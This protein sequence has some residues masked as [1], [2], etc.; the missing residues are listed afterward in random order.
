MTTITVVGGGL[1]GL[2][3]GIT[4]AEAGASVELHEA[5]RMLGGR[6]RSTQA[7]FV[8]NFGP[9]A[10][11][12][13]GQMWAWLG[14]RGLLP[15]CN[16]PGY[17][18]VLLRVDGRARGTAPWSMVRSVGLLRRG[19]AP[20]DLDFRTW[21]AGLYGDEAA[22]RWSAAAGVFSFTADPGALSAAFV[23][24]RLV[25]V[26]GL[27]LQARFPVGGWSSLVDRMEAHAERVG[28]RIIRESPV[29][30]LPD[31]P[32]IVAVEPVVARKLLGDE[33]LVGASNRVVLLDLGLRSRRGDAY[34]V[35]DLD[36]AGFVERYSLK[37]KT[38]APPGHEL[39][40]G[41][42]GLRDG[43][44]ADEGVARLEALVEAGFRGFAEREAWRR[45]SVIEGRSGAIDVPGTTWRDRPA[46][47]RD[48]DVWLAG[49][50]VAAPGTLGEVAW[51]SGVEAGKAAAAVRHVPST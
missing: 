6:A 13:D 8:A 44:S 50:W 2:V 36:T 29:E 41:Q 14:E 35:A 33:S 4:A 51:A 24:E 25:R 16:R 23:H 30:S 11:Y 32:S 3:A 1:A 20:V 49:D 7:P 48:G 22:A 42:M 40:Q 28:V 43:E 10:L 15:P 45:R 31:G 19:D 39:V 26:L 27:P 9:H 18:G 34:V 37:D 21:V 38:L 17:L 46:V 47:E 12:R 5:H